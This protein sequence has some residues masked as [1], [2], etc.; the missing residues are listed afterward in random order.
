MQSAPAPN[1]TVTMAEAP[2]PS[3]AR[4]EQGAGPVAQVEVAGVLNR[5]RTENG[6]PAMVESPR[7]SAAARSY[8]DLMAR[9][10]HFSHDGPDGSSFADRARAA[11]YG[12]ARAENIASGPMTDAQVVANWMTSPGHRRNILLSDAREFG[13]GRAG[14]K[15]VL[16]L[17]TGC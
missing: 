15:M 5:A 7:L 8:A 2:P 10:G 16:M 12:C 1:T 13:Y 17:G 11:G 6:R 3:A 9:T 4:V 14:D